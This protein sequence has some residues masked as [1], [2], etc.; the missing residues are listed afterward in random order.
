MTVQ[1]EKPI[2]LVGGSGKTGRRV[3]E[4]LQAKGVAIRIASRSGTPSFDWND[5]ATW[6]AALEGTRAAYITY[7][8]DLAVP[9]AATAVGDFVTLALEHGVKRL[10]LLSGR[11]EEEAQHAEDL[12]MA[13]GADWTVLRCAWFMQNFSESMLLDPLLSGRVALPVGDV[14]EPF[15]HADDI[16]DAAVA[17]LTQA[18]HVGKLYE[19]TGPR[20]ISFPQAVAAIAAA[21]GNQIA[22]ERI[23]IEDFRAG[24]KAEQIPD[25]VIDFL[26]VLFTEVMDGR[27]EK[28]TDGVMQVLGRPARD[29]STYVEEAA[30]TGMWNPA[31]KNVA[32]G[33]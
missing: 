30:A 32:K 12:L 31:G 29:F 26:L 2:L 3:A 4:R 1:S 9:G 5:R 18:G 22:F 28:T 19:L 16:A 11:G 23:S 33:A 14:G 21:S 25:D 7:F 24:L 6:P 27:N 8:P 17:A 15:I 10:V 13:S 20:L